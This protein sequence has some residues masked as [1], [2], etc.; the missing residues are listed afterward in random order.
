MPAFLSF[1]RIAGPNLRQVEPPRYRKAVGPGGN[2]Q[3]HSHTA[4]LLFAH[5]SAVLPGHAHRSS[6]VEQEINKLR[7][8]TLRQL[9]WQYRELFAE[10]SPSSNR[11]HLFPAPRG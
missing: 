6:S 10:E 9:K 5:L 4:V 11:D 1:L 7:P 8:L 3:T 2:R